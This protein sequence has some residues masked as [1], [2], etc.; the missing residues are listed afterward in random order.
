MSDLPPSIDDLDALAAAPRYHTLLLEN[1]RV[2]VLDTTVL[3]GHR[4]PLHTHRWPAVQYI[5]SWSDFVR[6]D[7]QGRV[8]LDTRLIQ[9]KPGAGTAVWSGPLAPHTLENVGDLEL[10][11]ISVE[12]KT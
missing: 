10:R 5:V 7:A 8:V 3:P 11:V 2:R 1:E 4:V 12:L 6:C 9:A